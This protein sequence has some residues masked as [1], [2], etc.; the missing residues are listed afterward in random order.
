MTASELPPEPLD[1]VPARDAGDGRLERD[2]DGADVLVV[3]DDRHAQAPI[4]RVVEVVDEVPRPRRDADDDAGVVFGHES[5]RVL[6]EL[7]L[8]FPERAAHLEQL[9]VVG[10]QRAQH[11]EAAEHELGGV[12]EDVEG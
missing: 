1:H 10:E 6:V 11:R 8:I 4:G 2:G 12:G 7:P 9:G 3:R 5:E